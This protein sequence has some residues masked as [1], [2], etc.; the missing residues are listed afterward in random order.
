MQALSEAAE[1]QVRDL[2]LFRPDPELFEL[3]AGQAEP[4]ARAL[5]DHIEAVAKRIADFLAMRLDQLP[6]LA[7]WTLAWPDDPLS[8]EYFEVAAQ[9]ATAAGLAASWFF[10][11]VFSVSRDSVFDAVAP[12]LADRLA[13]ELAGVVLPDEV[14]ADFVTGYREM[15]VGWWT[16]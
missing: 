13:Q 4:T 16:V 14:R 7:E 12:G 8:A 3:V 11:E 9:Q 2:I 1:Q 10:A 6:T 15:F 5:F